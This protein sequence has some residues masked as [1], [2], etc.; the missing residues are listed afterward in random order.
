MSRLFFLKSIGIVF[1]YERL[2]NQYE[3]IPS[4]VANNASRILKIASSLIL[5]RSITFLVVMITKKSKI[6]VIN[7]LS[8]VVIKFEIFANVVLA[9][10][11]AV[12]FVT[13]PEKA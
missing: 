7:G 4:K 1:S 13:A 8:V 2:T 5:S 12:C 10:H 3:T 11:K 9:S 6:Y